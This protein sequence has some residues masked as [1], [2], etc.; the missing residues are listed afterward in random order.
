MKQIGTFTP[1]AV[2]TRLKTLLAQDSNAPQVAQEVASDLKALRF[3]TKLYV[4]SLDCMLHTTVPPYISARDASAAV[5]WT[6]STVLGVVAAFNA[7]MGTGGAEDLQVYCC[8]KAFRMLQSIS[9][10]TSVYTTCVPLCSHTSCRY[11]RH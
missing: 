4:T 8:C 9:H 3:E 11:R 10:L 6:V 2:L 7:Y 1:A 5:S